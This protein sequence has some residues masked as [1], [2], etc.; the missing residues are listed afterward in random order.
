MRQSRHEMRQSTNIGHESK[1]QEPH[2][3]RQPSSTV[4]R[5]ERGA[6]AVSPCAASASHP[7]AEVVRGAALGVVAPSASVRKE[8]ARSRQGRRQ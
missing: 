7:P 5:L 3:T 2:L 1:G 6:E 4:A 8:A